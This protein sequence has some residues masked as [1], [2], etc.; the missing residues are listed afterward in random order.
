MAIGPQAKQAAQK[1]GAKGLIM[2]ISIFSQK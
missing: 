2:N 1:Y